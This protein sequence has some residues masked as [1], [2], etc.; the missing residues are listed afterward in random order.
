MSAVAEPQEMKADE[1]RALLEERIQADLGM[2]VSE[3]VDAL[4]SGELDPESS[5]VAQYAILFARTR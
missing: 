3:F 5:R 1:L 2:T 4:R